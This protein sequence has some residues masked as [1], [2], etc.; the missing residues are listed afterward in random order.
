MVAIMAG[1]LFDGWRVG[2][3]L[4]SSHAQPRQSDASL[5][6]RATIFY[7]PPC[8]VSCDMLR[9][10][11]LCALQDV[12]VPLAHEFVWYNASDGVQD[13][14]EVSAQAHPQH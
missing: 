4:L 1:S 5:S 8:S 14:R 6:L 12:E 7:L 3:H 13:G 11:V 9:C 10:A 2:V